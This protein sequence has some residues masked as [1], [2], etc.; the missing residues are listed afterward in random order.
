MQEA[1]LVGR[2]LFALQTMNPARDMEGFINLFF[3]SVTSS[4]GVII[5]SHDFSQFLNNLLTLT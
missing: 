4:R 5:F 1:S 3:F 2:L